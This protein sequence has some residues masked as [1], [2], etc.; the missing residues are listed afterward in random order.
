[1]VRALIACLEGALTHVG[2]QRDEDAV[3]HG[4]HKPINPVGAAFTLSLSPEHF[5]WSFFDNADAAA[6]AVKAHSGGRCA[7][8][9][10][11]V[12]VFGA[13]SFVFGHSRVPLLQR[14]CLVRNPN[15]TAWDM[16]RAGVNRFPSRALL[17]YD[18][19]GGG[20]LA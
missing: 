10:L 17:R 20:D 4:R 18:G 6:E 3:P 15:E 19:C 7:S 1:L 12:G 5:S 13:P 16:R 14:R 9:V 11:R 8:G 2:R